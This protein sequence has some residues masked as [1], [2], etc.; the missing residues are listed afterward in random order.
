MTW[1]NWL[2]ALVLSLMI[3]GGIL[4]QSTLTAQPSPPGAPAACAGGFTVL[5][6][7]TLLTSG[8]C[9]LNIKAG[10]GIVATPVADPAIGGTDI[11]FSLSS[12]T[13]P[14]FDQLHANTNYCQ[15][16]SGV[17]MPYACTL[18]GNGGR[19]SKYSVGLELLLLPDVPCPITCSIDV[20]ALSPSGVAIMQADGK[21]APNGT[22]FF[23][24]PGQ[25]G[26]IWYDGNVFR[27]E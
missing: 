11:V 24:N 25:A 23:A 3:C 27:M 20:D 18:A 21:T 14:T 15:A 7:G 13:T 1:R 6:N 12:A 10:T 2:A 9:V 19:L 16:G 8:L 22:G 17:A 26:R 5:L 4:L